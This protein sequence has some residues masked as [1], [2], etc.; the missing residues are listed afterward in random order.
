M[1]THEIKDCP[2]CKGN[3]ECKPGNIT[4]CQCYGLT[5]S[6]SEKEYIAATY[7]D[8]LC[9]NCLNSI[10]YE[11]RHTSANEKMRNVLGER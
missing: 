9:R 6:E 4:E 1:P 11:I 10:K 7:D 3:F 8:C 2:R 5:F